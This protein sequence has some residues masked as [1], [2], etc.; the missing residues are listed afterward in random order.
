MKIRKLFNKL[1]LVVFITLVIICINSFYYKSNAEI[2]L[3]SGNTARND[4][5]PRIILRKTNKDN[6]V[7]LLH[8][9]TGINLSKTTVTFDG[10]KVNL[11]LIETTNT[12]S[13]N[14]GVYNKDGK[15][16]KDLPNSN[17]Y[18]G[19]RY[20]YG[21]KISKSSLSNT[22]KNISIVAYDYEGKCY[23]RETLKAK[24]LDKVNKSGEQFHTDRAPRLTVKN[25]NGIVQI[26]AE[27]NSGIKNLKVLSSKTN[28]VLFNWSANSTK[29]AEGVIN[30]LANVKQ[31]GTTSNGYMKNGVLYPY[32]LSEIISYEKA[33]IADNKYK[34]KV[35]AEDVSGI[36]S[37]KTMMFSIMSEVKSANTGNNSRNN[38]SGNSSSGSN[39]TGNS[40]TG[41]NNS[42]NNSSGSNNTGNSSSV[43][44]NSGNNGSGSNSSGSN[45]SKNK[46]TL[47]TT[48][49]NNN[50]VNN[51]NSKKIKIEKIEFTK[52]NYEVFKGQTINVRVNIT[53]QNANDYNLSWVLSGSGA[54][55]AGGHDKSVEVNGTT[56][57]KEL[58]LR[59]VDVSYPAGKEKKAE[60]KIKVKNI[61]LNGFK[62]FNKNSIDKPYL[63]QYKKLRLDVTAK[64]FNYKKLKEDTV[65]NSSNKNVAIVDGN[66]L[67]TGHSPGEAT[68]TA[69]CYGNKATYKVI[70]YTVKHNITEKTKDGK[71]ALYFNK[72]R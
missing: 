64:D 17:N 7:V 11:T 66:G 40:S 3:E 52:N 36:K 45:S 19:K 41:S 22:Y 12:N 29:I 5:E 54:S 53:P 55:L 59:V 43:S 27:D 32:K 33:K 1:I 56:S 68:I 28:E 20:D 15:R 63:K 8:D 38:N 60:C 2:Q 70:V 24:K 16:I 10:K 37:E 69:S 44:K 31:N 50:S 30:S 26:Y 58:T 34:I 57:G 51:K 9:D 25:S 35:I 47:N 48:P 42:G 6:Y 13:E 46:K 71:L 14:T 72:K 18:N 65:W 67:V 61:S 23:L 49:E 21:F 39:N 4:R 62:I